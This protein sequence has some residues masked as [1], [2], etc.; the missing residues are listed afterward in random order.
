[1]AA[2]TMR[3]STRLLSLLGVLAAA[4][5]D[6]FVGPPELAIIGLQDGRLASNK[7]PLEVAFS[8]PIDP[9]SLNVKVIRLVTDP[10]DN[11]EGDPDA[12]P[13]TVSPS[14]FLRDAAGATTGGT[15][16]LLDNNMRLR[17]TPAADVLFPIGPS[18]ALVVEPGLHST[19]DDVATTVR[20][21]VPFGYDVST[22]PDATPGAFVTGQYYFLVAVTKPLGLQVQ[23]WA[24]VVV[25][26]LTGKFV[27]QFTNADRRT[28]TVCPTP[29][30]SSEV[31]RLL[32]A[33]ACVAPS[34]KAASVDEY[35]DYYANNVP[36]AGFTFTARG[37][38]QEQTP[39]IVT[40]SNEPTDAKLAQP[41]VTISDIALV[42]SFTV[43]AQG[44]LRGS[45]TFTSPLVLLGTA[46]S[47]PAQGTF[48]ARIIPADKRDPNAPPPPAL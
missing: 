39:G 40:F 35:P 8:K 44:V 6:S 32:P 29:C 16:E 3:C 20:R 10:E 47:G 36:K 19:D 31:C 14:L 23:L 17:I 25:D 30:A 42:G 43:D 13:G 2:S 45:G 18:L 5:C 41:N 11:I 1:M 9:S 33:P 21:R 4:S 46:P 38:A 7:A 26:P 48:E 28:D 34:E 27:G 24:D 12:A 37:L 22:T 15:A